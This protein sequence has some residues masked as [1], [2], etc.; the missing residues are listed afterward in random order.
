MVLTT[1][2]GSRA[3]VTGCTGP[4]GTEI[5]RALHEKGCQVFGVD[6]GP[7]NG[8]DQDFFVR[9]LDYDFRELEGLPAALESFVPHEGVDFLV[10]NA[11]LTPEGSGSGF[12]DS[13]SLQKWELFLDAARVNQ[14]APF[15]LSQFLAFQRPAGSLKS[16]VNVTST[17]GK[18]GPNLSIYANTSMG[19][20]AAYASTKG[21][22]EQLTKYLATV[23]AP[24]VR[25]NAVAPGGIERAQPRSFVNAYKSLTPL[26]RMNTEGDVAKAVLFLL[27]DE[28][29][30]VTGQS[31]GV[32]GGWT[33]W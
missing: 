19:N 30:Y 16:I 23:L 31:L 20:S 28:A 25:V 11:A 14:V 7:R 15:V 27:G 9:Y 33:A 21:G 3:L 1:F 32:D 13:L 29:S 12:S 8:G 4:V 24:D 18:V 5:S 17:Y 6:K 2:P 26:Q 10:N 22:L